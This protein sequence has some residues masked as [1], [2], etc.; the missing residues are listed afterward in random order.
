MS[1]PQIA[2]GIA[3]NF[4][5]SADNRAPEWVP[6]LPKPDANGKITGLDGR[7]FSIPD[8][9]ALVAELN[10]QRGEIPFDINHATF[11]KALQ[12]DASPAIGWPEEFQERDGAIWARPTWSD[13]GRT[14][15]NGRH[16]RYI[17]PSIYFDDSGAVRGLHSLSLTNH[18]NFTMPALNRRESSATQPDK[19]VLPM[20][21][22]QSICDRLN[23]NPEA[24]E[25]AICSAIDE[26]KNKHQVALNAAKTPDTNLYVPRPDYDKLVSIN[27]QLKAD[28]DVRAKKDIEAKVDA[29]I[30][31]GLFAPASRDHYVALCHTEGGVKIFEG[32]VEKAT[33][34][35]EPSNL[36]GKE[37]ALNAK[38]AKGKPTAEDKAIAGQLG[39]DPEKLEA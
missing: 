24:S 3:L 2:T 25:Q 30:S 20:K 22:P 35:F 13:E 36:D 26:L 27:T 37:V 16:Y 8:V 12:G 28:A 38:G 1:R 4:Q 10:A 21:F 11:L 32:L 7:T 9:G 31:K 33:P 18:P 29:A 17:S 34:M 5:L 6:V 23:L 19:E 14:A 39:L 15:L